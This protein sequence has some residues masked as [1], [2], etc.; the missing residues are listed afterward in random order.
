ML[1]FLAK[2]TNHKLINAC[3]VICNVKYYEE[4]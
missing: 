2:K 3:N 4:K 1:T